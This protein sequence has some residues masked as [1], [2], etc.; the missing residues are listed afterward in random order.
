[1][2]TKRHALSRPV[3]QW[4]AAMRAADERWA[5]RAVARLL[6]KLRRLIAD[7]VRL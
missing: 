2:S 4:V 5:R 6:R 7:G 3:R 1:M